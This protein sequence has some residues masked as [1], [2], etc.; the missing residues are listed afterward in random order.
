[1]SST[2]RLLEKQHEE[3]VLASNYGSRAERKALGLVW[4]DC[5]YPVVTIG[6]ETVLADHARLHVGPT[7]PEDESPTLIV[8][9]LEEDSGLV[10]ALEQL[11]ESAPGVPV[12]VFGLRVDLH[13]TRILKSLAM[14]PQGKIG[15]GVQLRR[16]PL[17]QGLTLH[18]RSARDLHRLDAP[19]LVPSLEP[20]FDGGQGDPE[21]FCDLLPRYTAVC[22]GERLQS[23][24]FR[25]GVHGEHSRVRSLLMQTAVRAR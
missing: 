24:V 17:P 1:M 10:S 14:L 9:G 13:A 11:R 18:R 7:P 12:L 6:L 20:A 4:I 21:E 3:E 2:A 8:L 22:C 5:L 15:V 16:Q 23:E 25:V 19:R